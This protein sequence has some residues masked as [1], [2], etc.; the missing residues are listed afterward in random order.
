NATGQD[1]I[2]SCR[3]LLQNRVADWL[4]KAGISIPRDGTGK[5]D[6]R[7]ELSPAK[8]PEAEDVVADSNNIS[9]PKQGQEKV[10]Q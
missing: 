1:S 3:E 4:E 2:E 7:I 8:Y 10:Y 5:P 6:C 9:P